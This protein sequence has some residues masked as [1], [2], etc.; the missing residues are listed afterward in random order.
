[1]ALGGFGG[2]T[3][4]SSGGGEGLGGMGPGGKRKFGNGR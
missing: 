3:W 2:C 1:M 4:G